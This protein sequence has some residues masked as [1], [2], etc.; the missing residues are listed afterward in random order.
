M[1]FPRQTP[2]GLTAKRVL[3][4]RRSLN[5]P[6]VGIEGFVPGPAQAAILIHEEEDGGPNLAV[7]VRCTETGQVA[8]YSFEGDLHEASGLGL[9]IDAA[10]SFAESMGFLFDDDELGPDSDEA[11]RARTLERWLE[12]AGTEA[13]RA[14]LGTGFDSDVM[15][16]GSPPEE[17][18]ARELW[19]ASSRGGSAGSTPADA[20][21]EP[22]IVLDQLEPEPTEPGELVDDGFDDEEL[23]MTDP[24][25]ASSGA[26]ALTKFR[27]RGPSG[28]GASR[29]SPDLPASTPNLLLRLL[30]AF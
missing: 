29:R 9:G 5:S 20:A 17:T 1:F 28:S 15:V 27:G 19:L 24:L 25:V 2:L 22:P 16:F 8:I 6:V 4:L 26:G 13:D 21:S 14:T 10:H 3:G 23:L 11:A 30:S 7:A 12:V 18:G